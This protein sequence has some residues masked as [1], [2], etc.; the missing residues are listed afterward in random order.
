MTPTVDST[1]G[2]ASGQARIRKMVIE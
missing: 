1:T 2:A